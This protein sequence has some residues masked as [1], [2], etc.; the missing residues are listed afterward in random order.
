M[1]EPTLLSED[2]PKAPRRDLAK[3][4]R[5]LR[6]RHQALINDR[7]GWVSDWR[8]L[9]KHYQPRKFRALD[10]GDKTNDPGLTDDLVDNTSV[11]A[12]RVLAAGMQGGMTSP[13]RPWFRLGVPDPVL[14]ENS[15]VKEWLAEVQRVMLIVM[16]RSNFYDS[17]HQEYAELG[18]FST[19]CMFIME[20]PDT[21]VNYRTLTAGEYCLITNPQGRVD[22]VFRL[23]DMTAEQIVDKFGEENVSSAVKT[24]SE[25]P[26]T[27]DKWFTV[28]HVVLPNKK[29][30]PD[31]LDYMGKAYLS[32]YY[33]YSPSDENIKG[34]YLEVGGFDEKPF[35][36]PRWDITGSD[37]YGR[38]PGM[39]TLNDVRQL[40]SMVST[41]M[42]A[43]H[44]QA[45]PPV[46]GPTDLAYVD[47]VPGAVN[48]VDSNRTETL[49]PLYEV[50]P[51]TQGTMV[52]ID[53]LKQDIREGLY[54]DL[55]KML[56]LATKREM[57]AHE[58]SE[59][60]E[61]K[62]IMLGPVIERLHSELLDIIIDRT[63]AICLRQGK[64]PPP[65]E[66]IQGSELKIEY[67]SLLAQAQKM[68][69]TASIDQFLALLGN[70]AEVFPEMLDLADTDEIGEGYAD[71]MGI[72][73]KMVRSR[74]EREEIR[75][76]RQEAIAEQQAQEQAIGAAQTMKT[77]SETDMEKESALKALG[78]AGGQG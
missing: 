67:I 77:M 73:P 36:G 10:E 2:V 18:T 44:K 40:Q 12:M 28:A 52:A 59:R 23:I 14:E 37:I 61:E 56:A 3:E 65:P 32:Y 21:T 34:G 19:G 30:K 53:G 38:G 58:V 17:I 25:S 78:A 16:S 39:D 13:A 74:D 45:D 20:D 71:M 54:N 48:M 68:I 47:T 7:V 66:E 15:Q 24:A 33:E 1:L 46:V 35:A 76:A 22:G 63:F 11:R 26:G 5:K 57:T 9:A 64:F 49:R 62:L 27:E 42:K 43:L 41:Q 69:G 55:F 60:V 70:Y 4:I 31:R 6:K 72:P 50:K 8:N 29:R 51:D 75:Q